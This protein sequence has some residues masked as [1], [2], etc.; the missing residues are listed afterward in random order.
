VR[1]VND[2]DLKTGELIAMDITK[3][4][5]GNSK[6]NNYSQKVRTASREKDS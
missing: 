1:F 2:T 5:A 3:V 6:K 4:K